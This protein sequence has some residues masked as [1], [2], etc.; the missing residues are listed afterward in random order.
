LYI[1]T[2]PCLKINQYSTGLFVSYS[3]KSP[4]ARKYYHNLAISGGTVA[5]T[6]SP[7]P[8]VKGSSQAAVKK[9]KK[10]KDHFI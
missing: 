5:E 2:I 10:H 9:V 4:I 8:K 1:N 3:A 7:H 6:L